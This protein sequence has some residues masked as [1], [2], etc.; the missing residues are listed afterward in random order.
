MPKNFINIVEWVKIFFQYPNS[1][2]YKSQDNQV[3]LYYTINPLISKGNNLQSEETICSIE[4]TI[5]TLYLIWGWYLKYMRNLKTSV[6]ETVY[7]PVEK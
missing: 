3:R 1:I 6:A 5:Y 2:R 4:E 7:N